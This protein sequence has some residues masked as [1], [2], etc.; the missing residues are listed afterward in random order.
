MRFSVLLDKFQCGLFI[1]PKVVFL[2]LL[3]LLEVI[4]L[5]AS[6]AHVFGKG[7]LI[8]VNA[9]SCKLA[10]TIVVIAMV[11]HALSIIFPILVWAISHWLLL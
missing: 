2:H 8:C 10:P 1:F 11:A 3:L 6:D 9:F 4:V 5:V 7:F